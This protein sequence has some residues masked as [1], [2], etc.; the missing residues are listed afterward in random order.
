MRGPDEHHWQWADDVVVFY[1]HRYPDK[2]VG[3]KDE[4][5]CPL[6]GIT[7]GALNYRKGNFKAV[8]GANGFRK[9]ARLTKHVYEAMREL[10][11]SLH[12]AQ[13]IGILGW[14]EH[15]RTV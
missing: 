8:E 3:Y 13:V 1:L 11:E 5:I 4:Q 14:K 2:P 6:L 12:R 15:R 7:I 10:P 9:Y